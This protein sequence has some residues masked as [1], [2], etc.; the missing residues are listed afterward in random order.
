MI[1][2]VIYGKGYTYVGDPKLNKRHTNSIEDDYGNPRAKEP[3][4][5]HL[6][7]EMDNMDVSVTEFYGRA[8]FLLL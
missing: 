8:H 7:S 4:H 3:P 6:N 2:N 5:K 1:H